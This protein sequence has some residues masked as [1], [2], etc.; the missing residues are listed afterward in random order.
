MKNERF[1][2]VGRV[3]KRLQWIFALGSH[4]GPDLQLWLCRFVGPV[5][6]GGVVFVQEF[7]DCAAGKIDEL[8]VECEC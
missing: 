4:C 2:S 6:Q 1:S 8:I 5:V 3:G 7:S